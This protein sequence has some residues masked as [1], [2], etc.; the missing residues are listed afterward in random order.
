M[1]ERHLAAKRILGDM[2]ECAEEDETPRENE[3]ARVLTQFL[4]DS[5]QSEK[6]EDVEERPVR[7]AAMGEESRPRQAHAAALA[8]DP[9]GKHRA[10]HGACRRHE[11]AGQ[12]IDRH[13]RHN[14]MADPFHARTS[15]F[16]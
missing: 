16:R 1:K 13:A 15:C 8:L 9:I 3:R 14:L 12:R 4:A 2:K 7:P 10:R 11:T 5:A 6:A